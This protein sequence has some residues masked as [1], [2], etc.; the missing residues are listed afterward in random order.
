MN[1]L[2]VRVAMCLCLIGAMGFQPVFAVGTTSSQTDTKRVSGYVFDAEGNA[3]A[4]A[5]VVAKEAGRVGTT[6]DANGYFQLNVAE[7]TPLTV[8]YIGYRTLEVAAGQNVKVTM[9]EDSNL[10]GDAVVVGYGTQKKVNLTGAVSAVKMDDVL[11]DR[12]VISTSAALQGA[13]PG[14]QIASTVG[15]PGAG[16]NINVRGTTSI[17]GGSPLVLVNNVP[18]DIELVDP[19]DIE[20]ISVLK[21]AASAAIYGARAGYGVILITTKQ[22]QKDTPVKINYNNNFAFSNPLTLPKS[23]TPLESVQAYSKMGFANDVHVCGLNIPTWLNLIQQYN[24][25]PS[26]YPNGIAT[27]DGAYYYLK[28]YDLF[29]DMTEGSGFQHNHN[30]S[31]NGGSAKTTY[32]LGFGYTNEDGILITDKDSYKR[33]NVSSFIST[34]VTKWLTA[35]LDLRYVHGNRSEVFS[36]GRSGVWGSAVVCPT[37][38]GTEDFEKDGVMYPTEC[39]GTYIRY[40]EPRH[41]KTNDV[42]ALGRIIVAPIKGLKLTAEYTFD[43]ADNYINSYVNK[44]QYIGKGYN[45]IS[46]ST[47]TSSYEVNNNYTNYSALNI[48]AN[49]DVAL[50]KDGKHNLGVTLG[51]NQ[52]HSFY[53]RVISSKTDV[54]L[55][56]LPS[57]N[58]SIGVPTVGDAFSEYSLRGLFFRV[59]YN[60]DDRYLL[61]IDGRY[62]GSSRFPKNDRFGFFPSASAAWRISNEAFMENTKD[63]LSNLKLRASYGVIG[64]QVLSNDYPYI[65]SMSPYQTTWLVDNTKPTTLDAP[66]MVSGSFTWEKI[67]SLDFGLDFGFLNNRLTGSFDWYRRDTKDMLAPGM[68]LPWVIGA[69]AAEQNA[70]D[71]STKGWELELMWK[72][73][74][75]DVKYYA[76]FNLY[77]SKSKITKFN[78]ETKLLGNY[79]EGQEIGEIWGYTTERFYTADDFN[80]DGTLKPGIA[81]PHGVST[82]NPGDIL[83]KD[84]DGDGDIYSGEGTADNPGDRR[85]IG[86]TT[87]RYQYGI[88]LGAEWKGLALDLRFRGVGKR[89]Y[90]RTDQLAWPTGGWGALFKETLDFW[91]EDNVNAFY[92][93]VYDADGV[94]T[95]VNHWVQTKYLAN[96]AFFSL[97]NVTLSYSLRNDWCQKMHVDAFKV[98]VNGENLFCADHLPAG[99][100][101][102]ML[103]LGAWN[104]PYM[105]KISFGFNVTF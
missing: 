73:K 83:Y 25:N 9:E 69:A 57:L 22:G 91:S 66:A 78:N 64:N 85:I 12:P 93:R 68:D 39:S 30:V 31:I 99:L 43:H 103:S 51:F 14:L 101:P 92:P 77:D 56:N 7:G 88:T 97:Q 72:D 38:Y 42:R 90:W 60:Y 8:S 71:L 13:V 16:M 45:N 20:S 27:V 89:D 32:R 53:E 19:Q 104:Y 82:I 34:D 35:Q 46:N 29:D 21:D 67:H 98:Y 6:T 100:H 94:N 70:A 36:G 75:G 33:T 44:Y 105:R 40:G 48:Y 59:N 26:L 18:M 86:N 102:E 80:A 2:F 11:G 54:L 84:F 58:G 63:W 62:D 41:Y 28:G 3:L 76:G 4:G 87:P 23:A 96:A 65:P 10:L 47:E 24:A 37:Y 61:E 55:P 74:I 17:N 52:E 95:G 79:Y 5:S 50:G 49:Y 81:K 15:A 1:Q